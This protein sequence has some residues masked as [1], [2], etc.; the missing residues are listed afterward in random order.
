MLGV[1]T[2]QF[3]WSSEAGRPAEEKTLETYLAE[4]KQAGCDG[5][6]ALQDGLDEGL[7]KH[8]LKLA[9]SYVNGPLHLPWSEV[10]SEA[11]L[12]KAKQAADLGGHYLAV[13]CDPKGSWNNR[14]RKTADELKQQGEN[15][16]RLADAANELGLVLTMHNHANQFD[17][18]RGDLDAVI[19]YAP[20]N[21]GLCLDTGWAL[22][23]EDDPVANAKDYAARIKAVHLRNQ[24]GSIPT[25]W[26]GEGDID[27]AAVLAPIKAVGYAGWLTTELWHRDDVARTQS[28]MEN[29]RRSV[30]LL[31]QLWGAA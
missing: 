8:G 18:H 30:D 2:V 3:T 15:L 23:S 25:E 14:E 22:T 26:L 5:V 11:L 27:M 7:P 24:R 9:G 28:L 29:Q 20:A 13:N 21:V 19:E 17:L 10:D 31:H 12:A 1:A 6:E 16:G 4:A